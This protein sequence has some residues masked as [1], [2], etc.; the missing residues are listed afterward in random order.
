MVIA[1]QLGAPGLAR[2]LVE[3]GL[4]ETLDE[5]CGYLMHDW[6]EYQP[7]RATN[8]LRRESNAER[9]ARYRANHLANGSRNAVTNASPTRPVPDIRNERS[10][11]SR[12][13]HARTGS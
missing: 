7:T 8:L 5:P 9:Q 2:K 4:W 3:V 1:R 10:Q 12:G 6:A 11:Q 13:R